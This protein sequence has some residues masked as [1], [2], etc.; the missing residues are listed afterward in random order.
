MP[1]QATH[2]RGL[3]HHHHQRRWHLVVPNAVDANRCVCELAD[4]ALWENSFVLVAS[5]PSGTLLTRAPE[6]SAA[7]ARRPWRCKHFHFAAK[8]LKNYDTHASKRRAFISAWISSTLVT[9]TE[10]NWLINALHVAFSC[11]LGWKIHLTQFNRR[12][13][14]Y[15][16]I[17]LTWEPDFFSFYCIISFL[18]WNLKVL[19]QYN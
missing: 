8:A 10:K 17:A 1:T 2:T 6:F 19:V 16:I 3:Y 13:L 14:G 11:A 12:F 7:C 15:L 4:E 18:R 5:F 9:I